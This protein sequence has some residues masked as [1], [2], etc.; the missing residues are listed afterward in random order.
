MFTGDPRD[1]DWHIVGRGKEVE[2]SR[3]NERDVV[4]NE[5][6]GGNSGNQLDPE[7][8]FEKKN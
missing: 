5:E 2:T 8:S 7:C 3:K 1:E 6:R 4:E